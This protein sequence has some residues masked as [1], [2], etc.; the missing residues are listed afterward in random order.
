MN[1]AAASH[2]PQN[3]L[4][5]ANEL[6]QFGEVPTGVALGVRAYTLRL[7]SEYPIHPAVIDLIQQYY[8]AQAQLT[9]IGNQI[10]PMF[11][12][13]HAKDLERFE[14][15]RVNEQAWDVGQV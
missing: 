15:P 5:V 6:D 4:Q 9:E 1:A 3:M 7:Q 13:V 11:R 10:G 12:Q 2:A 8:V 14:S